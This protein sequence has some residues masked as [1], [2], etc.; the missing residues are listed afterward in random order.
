MSPLSPLF[1]GLIG[2]FLL[3][4]A[5]PARGADLFRY[6]PDDSEVVLCLDV[7]KF[8]DTPLVRRHAPAVAE[9]YL[10]PLAK[11]LTADTEASR[12]FLQRNQEAIKQAMKDPAVVRKQL[13]A[14]RQQLSRIVL[15][16]KVEGQDDEFLI[17]FECALDAGSFAEMVEGTK[18]FTGREVKSTKVS[19]R[20]LY[21]IPMP[22]LEGPLY[23]T[24]LEKGVVVVTAKKAY[25]EEA[26]ARAAG[27][28]KQALNR[29]L[30]ALLEHVDPKQCAWMVLV[31]KEEGVQTTA[32]ITVN[33]K[34]LVRGVVTARNAEDARKQAQVVEDQL[35]EVIA[36]VDAVATLNK[37]IQQLADRLRTV[38]PVVKDNQV[39]VEFTV[40]DK[41]IG[42]VLK[43]PGK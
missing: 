8:L 13:Q 23:F 36:V 42:E 30:Q 27:K 19:G 35:K 21:E 33:E 29:D 24:L 28:R 43:V 3:L 32:G 2:V 4:L 38:K 16:G 1:R 26:M 14:F 9:Q 7:D 18:A 17:L 6:L 25:A 40:E 10:L 31:E 11:A 5:A 39:I 12:D 41:L 22:G 20:D 34:V 15:A 37:G